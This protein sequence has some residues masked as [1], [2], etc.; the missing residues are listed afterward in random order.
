MMDLS[1]ELLLEIFALLDSESLKASSV[2]CKTWCGPAQSILLRSIFF[3]VLDAERLLLELSESK[4]VQSTRSA[5]IHC[6]HT[7]GSAAGDTER[8]ES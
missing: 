5:H 6:N 8:I 2:T 1:P 3:D 7:R 4:L